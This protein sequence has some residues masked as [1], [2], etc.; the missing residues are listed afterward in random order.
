MV[1]IAGEKEKSNTLVG[2]CT[3]SPTNY[4]T[5]RRRNASQKRKKTTAGGGKGGGDGQNANTG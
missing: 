4:F 3:A 2:M 1:L 5:N